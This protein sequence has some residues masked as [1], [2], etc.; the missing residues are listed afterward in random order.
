MVKLSIDKTL[1][2]ILTQ[3]QATS[4]IDWISKYSYIQLIKA[5]KIDTNMNI[6]QLLIK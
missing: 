1:K 3:E 2:S 6:K 5:N 4:R